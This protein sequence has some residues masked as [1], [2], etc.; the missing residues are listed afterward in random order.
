MK[1]E[2]FLLYKSFYEP[3]SDLP[4]RL[5]GLLF[6]A[7][8]QYQIN[9]IEPEKSSPIYIAFKFIKNQFTLDNNKYLAICERNKANGSKG[10]RP[11]KAKKPSGLSGNPKKQ[12]KPKKADND[13]DNENEKDNINIPAFSDFE[14]YALSKE[15]KL[16]LQSLKLKYESWC[17]NN[18]K[19]GN[20]KPIKNWRSKL[21]NTIPYLKLDDKSNG[22]IKLGG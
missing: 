10:G 16:N 8:F 2:S 7:I 19:D 5:K 13:N 18:W 17:E 6:D 15:P 14:I 21:L 12:S 3:V 11:K 4:L 1:K 22:K 20:N 9:G